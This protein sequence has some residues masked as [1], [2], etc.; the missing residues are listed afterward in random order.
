MVECFTNVDGSPSI[1]KIESTQNNEEIKTP[2]FVKVMR[3]VTNED[4]YETNQM[5]QTNY[6]MPDSDKLQIKHRVL[7][8]KEKKKNSQKE[9]D[10]DME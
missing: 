4:V 8:E 3:E 7:K 1:L 6:K 2:P 5:A 10:D 9:K